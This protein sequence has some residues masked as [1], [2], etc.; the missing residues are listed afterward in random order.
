MSVADKAEWW[1]NERKKKKK[2]NY[3]KIYIYITKRVPARAECCLCQSR[4]AVDS[5][6]MD[7]STSQL[8][9]P[10]DRTSIPR[11]C[12]TGWS[13]LARELRARFR[14]DCNWKALDEVRGEESKNS[15]KN[16]VRNVASSRHERR[17][18]SLHLLWSVFRISDV[19]TLFNPTT[20]FIDPILDASGLVTRRSHTHTHTPAVTRIH[21]R[22][23]GFFS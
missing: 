6:G 14:R 22:R 18:Q 13:S 1:E 11:L 4:L 9:V 21:V 5:K 2:K 15:T 20:A 10:R 7:L 17:G 12:K 23:L 3:K 19:F 16:R 8:I